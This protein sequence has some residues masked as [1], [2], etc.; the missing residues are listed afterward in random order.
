MALSRARDHLTISHARRY[1][2]A[3]EARPSPFLARAALAESR[4]P[5]PG[6]GGDA[7]PLAPQAPRAAYPLREL[8]VYL[9]CPPRYRYEVVDGLAAVVPPSGHRRM[10]RAVLAA[11]GRM[12]GD[13]ASGATAT[14]DTAAA[15]LEA[16]WAT[17]GPVGHR[18]EDHYRGV[19][20]RLAS[21]LAEAMSIEFDAVHHRAT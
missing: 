17:N 20:D 10:L 8:E 4:H 19:A 9:A 16:A 21:R 12:E 3:R 5:D 6:D 7:E 18:W 14:Y 13:A 1:G 11:V 2:E 15:A